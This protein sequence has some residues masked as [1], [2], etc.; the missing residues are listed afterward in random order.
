MNDPRSR[1]MRLKR[2]PLNYWMLGELNTQPRTT[3]PREAAQSQSGSEIVMSEPEAKPTT[4]ISQVSPLGYPTNLLAPGQTYET[5]NAT[6]ADIPLKRAPGPWWVGFMIASLLLLMFFVAVTWLF[7]KGVGIWGVNIPVA[8]GFAI[9]NFVWWIG[10]RPRGNIYLGDPAVAL[11]TLAHSDQPF[12]G[13]DDA[14]RGLLRR[15]DA[16]CCIWAGRGFSTGFY[17]IRTRCDSGRNSGVRWSGT[18]LQLA[19][20][21]RF[22]CCFGTLDWSL[23]WPLSAIAQKS[24]GKKSLRLLRVGLA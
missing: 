4:L 3:L 14:V 13:S 10:N 12:H 7:I 9:V 15:S 23:I 11:P 1:L 19:L 24:S 17:H 16:R 8:W 18:F 6:I 21:S 20:I 22:H 2:S 5:I